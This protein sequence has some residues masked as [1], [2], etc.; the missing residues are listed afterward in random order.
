MDAVGDT[1]PSERRQPVYRFVSLHE[2]IR[3]NLDDLFPDMAIVDVMRLP[4]HPQ[5]RLERDEEEAEDLLE[6]I[7]EE[8]RQRRFANVVRL[9]HGAGAQPVDAASS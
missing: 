7:E 5:R 4:R 1:S 9:E 8:L 2:L 6:L 3:H